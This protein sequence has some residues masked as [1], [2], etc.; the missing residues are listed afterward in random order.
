MNNNCIFCKIAKK[1]IPTDLVYEDDLVVA[2]NDINPKAPVHIL[3]V[4]KKHIETIDHLQPED[5]KLIGTVIFVAQKIAR[6]KGISKK[7]YRLVFNVKS[8]GGQVV[9]HIHLHLLGGQKLGS[10]A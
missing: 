7:G 10:V 3:I 2:F 8:H 1:I 4:P 9:D 5:E 6:E